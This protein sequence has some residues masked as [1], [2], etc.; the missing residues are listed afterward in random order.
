MLLV[1]RRVD[2]RAVHRAA[3]AVANPRTVRTIAAKNH[4]PHTKRER[5]IH[6]KV[7]TGNNCDVLSSSVF[8][9]QFFCTIVL[10]SRGVANIVR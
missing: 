4:L 6:I 1:T 9:S 10:I 7:Q 3:P 5:G 2:H 8:F